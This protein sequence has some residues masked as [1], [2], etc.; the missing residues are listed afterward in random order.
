LIVVAIDIGGTFTDLLGFDDAAKTFV[1][2]KSL[3]TPSQLSDGIIDCIRKS[4]LDG[5][6]IDELIHGSTIA[7]NTLIERKGAKTGLIVTT[8]TRDVYIIGRGNRPESYNLLFHRHRPL[9]SRRLTREISERTLAS[10]EIYR[11]LERTELEDAARFFAENGVEAVAVCF[12]HSYGNPDHERIAGE[13]IREALPDAYVSLSHEI[14]RE[15]REFERMSTTVVN[16]YVGPRVGGYVKSLASSLGEAGFRGNLSIMRSNGG[17][18]SPE[19]ATIH[20]VAMMESGPVGGIIAAARVGTALGYPNVI[21]FDMGGTTAKASLIQ[22][23]E[24][25]IAP[26]YY[27]GGYASGHPVMIPLVDIVEVGAGGGS[28]AWIDE[29]GALKVGPQS[30]GADPG[31]MCYGNGGMEPTITDANVVLG[32]LNPNDFLGGAMQLDAAAAER[33]IAEHIAAPLHLSTVASAQAIVQIAVSKMSLAVREVSVVK[34]F[35]PR[36]FVLVASGGAG[37]LHALAIARDLH[38]PTVVVP[39]FPSHFSALGMLL[40]D[41]RHDFVRTHFADL[42]RVDLNA[43]AAIFD[44]MLVEARTRLNGGKETSRQYQLDMRYVGQEFALSVPV[45][46]EQLAAG[47]RATIRTAFDQLYEHRYAY[48]SPDEPVEMINLRLTAY[49]RQPKLAFPRLAR[50]AKAAPSAHRDVY[51]SGTAAVSTPVY[52][53]EELSAGAVVAGPAIVQELGTT[54]VLFEGDVGTVADSG[55]LIVSVGAA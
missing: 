27:V 51:L 25:S 52:R 46:E 14:L 44:D 12:L 5:G 48:H 7:I 10:G 21:S 30:S 9:V 49:G 38:I 43:V 20:P 41:E 34:G 35:D 19:V 54:T 17:V 8:G 42:G 18:M 33:G 24:P 36:D 3:T 45:T 1:Q 47:D 22:G 37:P 16:A 40:A 23:G 2:A 55:E 15:Y 29:V 31:P 26:G 32:R 6:K 50:S 28:I 4:G 39:L 11:P 53:R 13:V